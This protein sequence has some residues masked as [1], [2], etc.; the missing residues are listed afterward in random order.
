MEGGKKSKSK[1]SE[2]NI[3]HLNN[4][5]NGLLAIHFSTSLLN[6]FKDLKSCSIKSKF[7]SSELHLRD[8]IA[9]VTEA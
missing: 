9:V 3:T 7:P 5:L 4:K 6:Y 2:Q 8:S 1:T